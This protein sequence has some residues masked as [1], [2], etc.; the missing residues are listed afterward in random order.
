[1]AKASAAAAKGRRLVAQNRKARY[2]YHIES[3]IE[4]GMVL[5]GTEVKALRQGQASLID[6]W[7]GERG[8]ELWLN[9]AYIPQYEAGS[10]FNHEPKRPRKLLVARRERDRLASA[11]QRAGMTLIPLA[12]YFNE[13]GIAKIELGVARGKQRHDKRETT[14]QRDWD[15]QKARLLRD[16]G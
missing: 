8:G 15:R 10:R 11:V 16:K 2:D 4:A 3:T 5:Q 7:A 12:I 13:R 1:M 9:N 14:K 6:A